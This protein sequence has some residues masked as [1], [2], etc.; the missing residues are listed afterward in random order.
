MKK[1]FSS[2]LKLV[3]FTILLSTGSV[4]A[5]YPAIPYHPNTLE[6]TLYVAPTEAFIY[7]DWIT[8]VNF[9]GINNTTANPQWRNNYSATTHAS[10]QR[11]QTYTLSVTVNS[12]GA[13]FSYQD[14]TAYIDW[15][16]DGDCGGKLAE[17]GGTGQEPAESYTLGG[18]AGHANPLTVNITIPNDAALG[19]T[20]LR[21]ILKADGYPA[22]DS[23]LG[24]FGYGEIEEYAIDVTAGNSAPTVTTQAVSSI[25]ATTATG[26]G[27]ITSLGTPNPTAYGV[28][29]NTTGTPTTSDSKVDKGAASATGAFAASMTSLTANTTYY[30]RAYATNTA[31]TSYGSDVNFTTSATVP[32]A[33]TS[34]SAVA[35]NAQASVSFTAPASNGGSAITG[36]TVTS[37]PGGLTGT[38]ATSPISV[39]GLTNGTAYTFT[40]TATNSVGTG[41]AS[42]ASSAV[43]PALPLTVTTQ[44]VSSITS[45][46]AIGNGNVTSLGVPNPTAHGVCWNTV[47][48]PTV[49]DSKID[50][51]G[52]SSTGAFTASMTSLSE[53]T[54]YYVRAY[55]TNTAGTSYG[56]EV[57]FT[58]QTVPTITWDNPSDIVYGT[59]LSATQL[60]ATASVPGTFTYTPAL[61]TLLNAGTVQNLKVDFT[62]TDA[63]NYSTTT[64]TVTIDVAKATPVITWSNPTG[65][66]YN[67]LLSATQL[68]A[69]ADAAGSIVYSPAL[70]TKLN[71]GVAQNLQA[72]FTPTDAANY[73]TATKTVT[74]DVAK[75]TPVITW[76][77]PAD[78]NNETALS[79]IQL[80]AIADIAG[81][82]TYTPAIG[83]KLNVGNAQA[84][85][86]DFE[87]TD[88]VNYESATKTVYINVLQ[89][90]GKSEVVTNKFLLFPNPVINFFSVSG[91][92]GRAKISLSDLNGRVILTKEISNNEMISLENLSRGAYIITLENSNGV[93]STTILKK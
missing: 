7:N 83:V 9:A 54:K 65:I 69:T 11:G 19:T 66:T 84:L 58:T 51:G 57:N 31:G 62:P 15:D 88:A 20:W 85:K 3:A 87:P 4:F 28:C 74:I 45:T 93:S 50:I 49:S 42:T 71:A 14:I 32:G 17:H 59:L 90:T 64:K 72:N 67:T 26:N 40:V 91:I 86:A 77:N 79:S 78:I 63:T 43:T 24:Y 33:P 12:D 10:V 39:T 75:A 41:S 92:E 46:T 29:W 47:G 22:T 89:A 48:T 37:S 56:T 73:N 55:A 52:K 16:R 1:N 82:F 34:V 8:N 53:N 68:N 6:P 76:S 70:G 35:G 27:N 80:N 2:F 23:Y 21:V 18:G 44:A 61:G 81:I 13:D 25:A 38:G 60:K 5:Q 36:Y 30:V